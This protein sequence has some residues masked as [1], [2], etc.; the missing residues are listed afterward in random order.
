MRIKNLLGKTA[1][2]TFRFIT[3]SNDET[4]GSEQLEF[5]DGSEIANVSKRIIVSGENLI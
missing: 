1:N 2:L 5:E 3:K 4:F